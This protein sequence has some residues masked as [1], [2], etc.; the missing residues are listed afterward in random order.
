[1]LYF[2]AFMPFL[3]IPDYIALIDTDYRAAFLAR[4]MEY[5][6]QHMALVPFIGS[7]IQMFIAIYLVVRLFPLVKV[8]HKVEFVRAAIIIFLT[9]SVYELYEYFVWIPFFAEL[10]RTAEGS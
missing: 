6:S 1:M 3:Y 5:F 8:I 7:L 10:V 4:N 9:G 2:S